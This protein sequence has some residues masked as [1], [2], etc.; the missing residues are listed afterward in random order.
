MQGTRNRHMGETVTER[1]EAKESVCK[2][3][4][5]ERVTTVHHIV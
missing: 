2:K 5:R 3:E 4:T 1:S